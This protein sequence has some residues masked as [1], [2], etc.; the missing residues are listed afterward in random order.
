MAPFDL[1]LLAQEAALMVLRC[2]SGHSLFLRCKSND[3]ERSQGEVSKDNWASAGLGVEYFS[4]IH[5]WFA[6]RVF[7]DHLF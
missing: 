3:S 5:S 4:C 1:P 2:G 7:L 6:S